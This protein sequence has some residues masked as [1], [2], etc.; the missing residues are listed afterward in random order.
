MGADSINS[1]DAKPQAFFASL[2]NN[3]QSDQ[4]RSDSQISQ[5]QPVQEVENKYYIPDDNSISQS[6]N[7]SH[8]NQNILYAE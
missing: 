3:F 2:N 6:I 8:Q 5:H 4:K 7:Q 1:Q